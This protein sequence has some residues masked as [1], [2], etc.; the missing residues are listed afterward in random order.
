MGRPRTAT[1]D[2]MLVGTG[3]RKT[4]RYFVKAGSPATSVDG[5]NMFN[6]QATPLHPCLQVGHSTGRLTRSPAIN[7]HDVNVHGARRTH[8]TK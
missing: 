6:A 7:L 3:S 5:R 2:V 8:V 1:L 4:R